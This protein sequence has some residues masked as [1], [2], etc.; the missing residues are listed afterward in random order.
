MDRP[1]PTIPWHTVKGLLGECP[2]FG[3]DDRPEF[4]RIHVLSKTLQLEPELVGSL[5]SCPGRKEANV[6]A[7]LGTGQYIQVVVKF[8]GGSTHVWLA[9]FVP[10]ARRPSQNAFNASLLL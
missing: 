9:S 5:P 8:E 6:S 4:N 2:N 7:I 10:N 3:R 1:G